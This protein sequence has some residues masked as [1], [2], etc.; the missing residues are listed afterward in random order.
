M[1]RI[2]IGLLAFPGL[3]QL[4][5]SGPAQVFANMP[6]A[7]VMVIWKTRDPIKACPV[8]SACRR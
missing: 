1:T 2:R 7:E 8:A 5:L 4:D 3:T 6:G